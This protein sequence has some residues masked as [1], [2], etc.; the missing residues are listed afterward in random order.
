MV[1]N[2]DTLTQTGE[3]RT[4]LDCHQCGKNFIALLDFSLQGNHIIECA[5]CGHEHCRVIV[6]GKVT[7][8]RWDSKWGD[9]RNAHDGAA[10]TSPS[11]LNDPH[12]SAGSSSPSAAL[13]Y[14]AGRAT[15]ARKMSEASGSRAP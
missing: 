8:D 4:D 13:R 3:V 10:E 15:E 7:G 6:R 11:R 5:H 2:T 14:E 9:K 12:R 1:Q